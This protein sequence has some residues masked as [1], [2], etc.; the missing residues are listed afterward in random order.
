MR[1]FW[2]PSLIADNPLP[3]REWPQVACVNAIENVP[4]EGASLILEVGCEAD[5]ER[6]ADI[7]EQAPRSIPVWIFDPAASV[8]S[9]VAWMKHGAA[10]VIT[11]VTDSQLCGD[12]ENLYWN[13]TITESGETVAV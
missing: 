12:V 8:G 11:S 7:L 5:S 9:S 2:L 3:P 6:A 10:H 4:L 13:R 1:F